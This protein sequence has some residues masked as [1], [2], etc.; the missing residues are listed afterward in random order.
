MSKKTVNR[1]SKMLRI[2]A[3]RLFVDTAIVSESSSEKPHT[4]QLKRSATNSYELIRVRTGRMMLQA[5]RTTTDLTIDFSVGD[6]DYSDQEVA[7]AGIKTVLASL[8][9]PRTYN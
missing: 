8:H 1:V 3:A 4:E 7:S 5:F 6:R 2:E 9:G